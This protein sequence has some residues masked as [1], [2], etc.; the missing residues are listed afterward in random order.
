M[1]RARQA[2]RQRQRSL[3][4]LLVLGCAAL[5]GSADAVAYPEFEVFI[6]NNSG[7]WVNCA[8][9]HTHPDGPEGVKPGQIRSLSPAQLEALNHARQAFDPGSDVDSPIL[10]DFGDRI[11]EEIGKRGV[12]E[13][14]VEDPAGLATALGFESDLDGDGIPDA[15]EYLAGTHPLDAQHGE[16]SRLFLVNLQRR[17][18]DLLML[19]AATA[20]GVW[21][22]HH[23]LS[24][25]EHGRPARRAARDSRG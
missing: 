8:F 23:L 20:C 4:F 14:R 16:P 9:C 5:L 15:R 25:F 24:Y 1:K 18:F 22:L 19:A 11:I 10:N 21:G 17:W 13:L 7:R 2:V 12:L 3:W 6:E